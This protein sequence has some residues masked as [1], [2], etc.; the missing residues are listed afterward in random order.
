ML[1]NKEEI[2]VIAVAIIKDKQGRILVSPGYDENKDHHFYRLLGGGV[3][4]G[5]ASLEALKRE[6]QEELAAEI[7]N[8]SLLKVVENIFVFDG[9]KGHEIAFIYK[10]E[11]VDISLY[12]KSEFKILDSDRDGEVIWLN[13]KVDN[14][15]PVYP[16]ITKLKY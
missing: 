10:A 5:E 16:D 12:N 4:F 1:K 8:C 14:Q 11:F 15:D 13:N 7:T 6:F 2:R 3:D 9:Q